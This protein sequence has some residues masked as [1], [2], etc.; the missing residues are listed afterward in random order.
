[1]IFSKEKITLEFTIEKCDKCDKEVKR[2]FVDGD[3]LFKKL[4]KC[5]SC[6]GVMIIDKIFSET[7]EK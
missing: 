3:S 2:K 5:S 7:I 6:E 4:S 1:M